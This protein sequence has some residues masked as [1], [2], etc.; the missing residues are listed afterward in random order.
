M[1]IN[2]TFQKKNA[3]I[4]RVI[5]YEGAIVKKWKY[6]IDHQIRRPTRLPYSVASKTYCEILNTPLNFEITVSVGNQLRQS[7]Q[8]AFS[9]SVLNIL[10]LCFTWDFY[11]FCSMSLSLTQARIWV[12]AFYRND[13]ICGQKK[14][15][16]EKQLEWIPYH[17]KS[18]HQSNSII[19]KQKGLWQMIQSCN[20]AYARTTD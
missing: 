8:S 19:R 1:N 16:E 2:E 15:N 13:V 14:I 7:P 11:L 10:S 4:Y 18:S 17:Q 12:C 3:Q 6:F 20:I 5:T 9:I